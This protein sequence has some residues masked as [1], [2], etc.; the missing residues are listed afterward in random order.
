MFA[1]LE[2]ARVFSAVLHG[3]LALSVLLVILP[4]SA[5]AHT[6][7]DRGSGCQMSGLETRFGSRDTELVLSV[8]S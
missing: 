5:A 8:C 6:Y 4:F 2:H 3:H 7:K 1:V